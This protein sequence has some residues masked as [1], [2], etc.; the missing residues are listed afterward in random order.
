[1]T[2]A[3][4]EQIL[5]IVNSQTGQPSAQADSAHNQNL[6]TGG[7]Q[8]AGTNQTSITISQ[9]PQLAHTQLAHPNVDSTGAIPADSS[10]SA[11]RA[12]QRSEP[13]SAQAPNAP[14]Q[15]NSSS[16][17]V[18]SPNSAAALPPVQ[19]TTGQFNQ[20]FGAGPS[21]QSAPSPGDGRAPSNSAARSS[22]YADSRE[23]LSFSRGSLGRGD[24]LL[25]KEGHVTAEDR[26]KL[27]HVL[28]LLKNASLDGS[29]G[30]ERA[31]QL[32]ELLKQSGIVK[33]SDL[34]SIGKTASSTTDM[35]KAVL[36]KGFVDAITFRAALGCVKLCADSRFKQ[37][38]AIIALLYCHRSRVG[39]ADAISDLNWP[40]VANDV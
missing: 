16:Q 35:I 12:Q 26:E 39:L 7:N 40:V 14:Q 29:E 6:P 27:S 15:K 33:A 4:V 17:S 19:R 13:S 32:L 31:H 34:E 28:S 22:S 5:G 23:T 3:T 36:V 24:E 1:M 11:V 25:E 10:D 38:Q 20:S 37:E 30:R 8:S 18:N 9:Q 21:V 2:G